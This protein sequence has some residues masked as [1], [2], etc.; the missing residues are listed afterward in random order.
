MDRRCLMNASQIENSM[1]F[2]RR[3]GIS[4]IDSGNVVITSAKK[5]KI[6]YFFPRLRCIANK[7]QGFTEVSLF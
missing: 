4:V 1:I 6:A 7:T 5:K 2:G 3:E